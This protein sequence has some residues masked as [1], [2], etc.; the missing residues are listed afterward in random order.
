MKVNRG[1]NESDGTISDASYHSHDTFIP[2]LDH[3]ALADDE[4]ERFVL[5]LCAPKLL[6]QITI[7]TV[8]GAVH[9][10]SAASSGSGT[11]SFLQND[12]LESHF[13]DITINRSVHMIC[14]WFSV[15]I[16]IR[17]HNSTEERQQQVSRRDDDDDDDQKLHF[18]F[19]CPPPSSLF[20]LLDHVAE[21]RRASRS[22]RSQ[23]IYFIACT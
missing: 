11:S 10:Y 18:Q 3:P 20:D 7:L 12:L 17:K 2:T 15:N 16:G 22:N 8:T 1:S 14:S 19:S 6:R 23:S 9:A 4:A 13:F 21:G 5:V